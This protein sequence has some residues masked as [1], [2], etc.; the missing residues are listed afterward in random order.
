MRKGGHKGKV[1]GALYSWDKKRAKDIE[2]LI[3]PSRLGEM[4]SERRQYRRL[5]AILM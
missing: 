1:E 4:K 3:L 5:R 2:S